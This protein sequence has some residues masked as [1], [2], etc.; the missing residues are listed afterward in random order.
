M[1]ADGRPRVGVVIPVS[2]HE[3]PE[4]VERA[5]DAFRKM[6]NGF[7][8]VFVWDGPRAREVPGARVLRRESPRG[9]KAGAINDAVKGSDWDVVGIFDVDAR[10][11]LDYIEET[12][13]TL[14]SDPKNFVASGPR[15]IVNPDAS[16]VTR[17]VEAE[18]RVL[19]DLYRVFDHIGGFSL[20]NGP[21]GLVDGAALREHPLNEA[22]TAEDVEFIN[23]MTAAGMRAKFTKR[24]RMGEQAPETLRDLVRQRVRWLTGAVEGLR[25]WPL[26]A[27]A[28]V[29]ARVKFGALALFLFPFF[30]GLLSFAIPL[31]AKRLWKTR[32][33]LGHFLGVFFGLV[34]HLWVLEACAL[35]ALVRYPFRKAH[36]AWK[37]V[38]RASV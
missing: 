9:K 24:T 27:R 2:P 19:S 11:D 4:I 37:P 32:R 3:P 31:Y 35:A 33:S 5:R 7:D 14:R 28:P 29:A 34:V 30:I 1:G 23:R 10:P 6:G 22:V 25:Q 16:W 21:N 20:F 17:W 26:L 38:K 15:V 13:R 12:V 36:R 8:L 18:Y